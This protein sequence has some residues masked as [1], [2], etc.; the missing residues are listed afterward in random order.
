MTDKPLP[1][2][3]EESE[4]I[5]L[6]HSIDAEAPPRL[7]QQVRSMVEERPRRRAPLTGGL[8]L[9]L[10]LGGAAVAGAVVALA[11]ALGSSGAGGLSLTEASAVTLRAATLPPPAESRRDR[12]QL[13]ASVDGIAFPYWGER[14]GWRQDGSRVDRI[15][16]RTIE[17]VFYGDGRGHRVGYAIVAGTPAPAIAAGSSSWRGG[18]RYRLARIGGVEVITWTRSGRLCVVSGRGVAPATLLTL[19]SW[20]E[21]ASAA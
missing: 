6:L 3:R 11:I 10:G 8:G 18:T 17:T 2:P 4:L 16:G 20:G 21:R 14:F 5:E 7:H 1:R 19:A 15:G 9:R 12:A 13:T